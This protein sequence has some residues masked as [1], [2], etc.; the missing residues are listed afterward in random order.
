MCMPSRDGRKEGFIMKKKDCGKFKEVIFGAGR[1]FDA[2]GRATSFWTGMVAYRWNPVRQA[3]H[4][5]SINVL[6]TGTVTNSKEY[7]TETTSCEEVNDFL[8]YFKELENHFKKV[9]GE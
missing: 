9:Y 8:D 2:Y 7:E 3:F 4:V 6:G 1:P 5:Y